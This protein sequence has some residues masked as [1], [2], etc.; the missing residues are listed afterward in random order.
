MSTLPQ[1]LQKK[2]LRPWMT[3]KAH[4]EIQITEAVCLGL[5][6][7]T[8]YKDWDNYGSGDGDDEDLGTNYDKAAL[9]Q[10]AVFVCWV[11]M[12]SE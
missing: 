3:L 12:L 1:V 7:L 6:H 9:G 4:P 8:K 2:W 11:D 10:L 5:G